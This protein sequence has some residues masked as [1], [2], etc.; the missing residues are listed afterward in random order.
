MEKKNPTMDRRRRQLEILLPLLAMAGALAYQII[1]GAISVGR[2][3]Q[4]LDDLSQEVTQLQTTVNK[5]QAE[6]PRPCYQ[7]GPNSAS[8]IMNKSKP[9]ASLRSA[10]KDKTRTHRTTEHP[11]Q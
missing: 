8:A 9:A 11:N 1:V 6:G 5:Q 7:T 10:L 2:T 4:R 3:T